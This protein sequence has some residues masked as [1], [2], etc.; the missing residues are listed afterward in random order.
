MERVSLKRTVQFIEGHGGFNPAGNTGGKRM[1]CFRPSNFN[2]RIISALLWTT[3]PPAASRQVPVQTAEQGKTHFCPSL[4]FLPRAR[5][6]HWQS[7]EQPRPKPSQAVTLPWLLHGRSC[8]R[9]GGW[10]CSSLE[11]K[12]PEARK[13]ICAWAEGCTDSDQAVPV[14]SQRKAACYQPI[15]CPAALHS[16]IYSEPAWIRL[17]RKGLS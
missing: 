4:C 2:P 9:A 8:V 5:N 13:H 17:L 14:H 16:V 12:N 6:S 10:S 7:K 11:G 1:E 3:L 15:F